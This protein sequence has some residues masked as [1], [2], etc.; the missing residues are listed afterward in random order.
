[1]RGEERRGQELWREGRRGEKR[2]GGEDW[3]FGAR[4]DEEKRGGELHRRRMK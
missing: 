4:E 1:M 3:S 2:K